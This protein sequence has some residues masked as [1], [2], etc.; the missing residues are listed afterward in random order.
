MERPQLARVGHLADHLVS[1]LPA[2]A[3]GQDVLEPVGPHHGDHPLLALRD[4]D[5]PGLHL[6]LAERHPVEVDVDAG[7]V[8]R[9]LGQRRGETGGAAVLERLDEPALGQLET[10]LDQLLARE[11]IADLNGRPLVGV[12]LAKLLTGENARAADPVP[13]RRGSVEDEQA[14]GQRRLRARQTLDRQQADTHGVHEAVAG[15]R[16]VEDSLAPDR[17]YPD[18]VPVVADPGH[19]ALEHE[20]RLA[21]P[22][23]VQERDR[24]GSHR[25][26]VAQDPSDSGGRALERLDGRR[27][28]VALDLEGDR[29]S[30]AEVEDAGVLARALEDALSVRGQPL[31]EQRRMLVA[32]MLGP[33][34]RE[35]RELEVVRIALEQL[36]D[37]VELLVRQAESSV[38]G[39]FGDPRQMP[40]SRCPGGHLRRR[41]RLAALVSLA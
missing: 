25:D 32:A 36:A 8:A 29:L 19:G 26:H 27:M 4:H 23:P 10:C 41:G 14:A 33:E 1:Q 3:E 28:V 16:F 21:E 6:V 17:R 37:T 30:A 7:T 2:P 31:Q 34:E 20:P 18:A 39:L 9:H 22:Q 35:H 15:V 5:L 40:H 38:E 12:F 13:A 11:R 24:P